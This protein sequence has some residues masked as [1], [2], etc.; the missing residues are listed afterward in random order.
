MLGPRREQEVENLD[1][2]RP[3]RHEGGGSIAR[4][5]LVLSAAAA[6]RSPRRL[7]PL[8]RLLP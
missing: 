5:C 7:A 1:A 6:G 4:S 8:N 3:K 2:G